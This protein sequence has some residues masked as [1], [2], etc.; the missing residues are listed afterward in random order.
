M[1]A[2]LFSLLI[3]L[4]LCANAEVVI[5]EKNISV[6]QERIEVT[7]KLNASVYVVRD[8]GKAYVSNPE[9][10][11]SHDFGFGTKLLPQGNTI[12]FYVFSYIC[13]K[14]GFSEAIA[15]EGSRQNLGSYSIDGAG[16]Y[17]V[18]ISTTSFHAVPAV[19]V[20]AIK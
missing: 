13:R 3:G 11:F 2:F 20:C 6:N 15:V 14:L 8:F 16:A 7:T 5:A 4:P 19:I 1:K 10:E 17:N 12:N 18:Q 9:F